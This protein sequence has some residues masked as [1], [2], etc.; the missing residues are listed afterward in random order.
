MSKKKNKGKMV[1]FWRGPVRSSIH[2]EVAI[3]LAMQHRGYNVHFIICDGVMSG[4][5]QGGG[6]GVNRPKCQNCPRIGINILKKNGL[7]FTGMGTLVTKKRRRK[8]RKIVN[9]WPK[10]RLTE[11]TFHGTPV[12]LFAKLS[13]I[14]HLRTTQL[15]GR[16]KML[17]EFLYS[18]FICTEAARVFKHRNMVYRL[19]MQRHTE[20]V[21]WAPAYTIFTNAGVKTTVWG[22]SIDNEKRVTLRNTGGFEWNPLYTLSDKTWRSRSDIPLTPQEDKALTRVL[23]KQWKMSGSK[24]FPTKTKKNIL[25]RLGIS[26]DKPIWCLFT[27]IVWDAGLDP[28]AMFFNDVGEWTLRTIREIE[29]SED[30]TWLVKAHPA[31]ALGTNETTS[32]IIKKNF[33]DHKLVLLPPRTPITVKDLRSILSGG[34][35]MQGSVGMQLPAFGIPVIVGGHTHYSNKGFT[36]DGTTVDE[37]SSLLRNAHNIKCLTQNQTTLARRYAYCLYFQCRLPLMM[38]KRHEGY[39]G[40]DQSKLR[41]LHPGQDA[42]MSLI[43]NRIIKGGDFLIGGKLALKRY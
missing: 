26:D 30:V 35:T 23:S 13:L 41:L 20:Y 29:K 12:G 8:F 6:V 1:L 10:D 42:V 28:R 40:L 17:R 5:I 43:C 34:V 4:C 19:F 32:D 36:S 39:R 16:E 3:A 31:E 15:A 7:S 18:A 2:T 21:G 38:N 27:P 14:R 9:T 22:G 37:F 24:E 25:T 33:P 11:V